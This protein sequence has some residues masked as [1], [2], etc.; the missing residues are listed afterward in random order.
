MKLIPVFIELV[1]PKNPLAIIG[2]LNVGMIGTVQ[3]PRNPYLGPTPFLSLQG[4]V[5]WMKLSYYDFQRLVNLTEGDTEKKSELA[6][7]A[8]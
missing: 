7:Q 1:D 3:H 6:K 5:C 8:N 4:E 2:M